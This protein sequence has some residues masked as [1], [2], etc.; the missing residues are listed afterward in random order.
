MRGYT[1]SRFSFNSAQGRC[2]ECEGAGETKLEMNFLPPGYVRCETCQGRRFNRETL[3]ILSQP[4]ESG[5]ERAL[6][7]IRQ[8]ARI[9]ARTRLLAGLA[10]ASAWLNLFNLLPVWQLDGGRGMRALAKRERL[11]IAGLLAVAFAAMASVA[12][13]SISM[14]VTRR[15][16]SAPCGSKNTS[17]SSQGVTQLTG[18]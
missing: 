15:L 17:S 1:A 18:S 7:R 9:D 6:V 12:Q 3:D 16:R 2:P 10:Q 11:M 14:K 8:Q 13:R 5:R 4:L